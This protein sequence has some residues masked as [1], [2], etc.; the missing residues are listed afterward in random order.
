MYARS[1]ASKFSTDLD[2][3]E[4]LDG[5]IYLTWGG[6]ESLSEAIWRVELGEVE[7]PSEL[8]LAVRCLDGDRSWTVPLVV[9]IPTAV[10]ERED[11]VL[12]ALKTAL[13][14]KP[15]GS[16]VQSHELL[17]LLRMDY[18]ELVGLVASLGEGGCLTWKPMRG[19]DYIQAFT[20]SRL[21]TIGLDRLRSQ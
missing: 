3:V 2:N 16:S 6:L 11:Y 9:E 4:M 18:K 21:S 17:N 13:D 1:P 7:R 15:P 12:H 20:V 19:G 5:S 8:A 14:Q 10:Y